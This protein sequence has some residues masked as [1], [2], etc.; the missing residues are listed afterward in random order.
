[1]LGPYL[2]HQA[3]ASFFKR[4]YAKTNGHE[5]PGSPSDKLPYG[6]D[7]QAVVKTMSKY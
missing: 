6:M 3:G 1:M 5:K 4:N 2:H 7:R